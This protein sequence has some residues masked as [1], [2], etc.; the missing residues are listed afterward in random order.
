[1]DVTFEPPGSINK[2]AKSIWLNPAKLMDCLLHMLTVIRFHCIV[3]FNS[4]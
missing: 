4:D 1:M 3:V 2:F